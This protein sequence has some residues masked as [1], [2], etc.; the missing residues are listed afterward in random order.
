[1]PPNILWGKIPEN[2]ELIVPVGITGKFPLTSGEAGW[3]ACCGHVGIVT[4]T[5]LGEG[6]I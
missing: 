2:T 4:F 1:M 3:E 5:V 6:N